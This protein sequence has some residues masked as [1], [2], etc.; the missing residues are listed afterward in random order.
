MK[1]KGTE[2]VE[3]IDLSNKGLNM[4][5][6]YFIARLIGSNTVTKSLKYAAAQSTRFSMLS[7]ASDASIGLPFAVSMAT[8]SKS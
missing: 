4:L 7:A 8:L 3:S 6:A 2:P 1:L 5:S